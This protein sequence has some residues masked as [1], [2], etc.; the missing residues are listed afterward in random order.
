MMGSSGMLIIVCYFNQLNQHYKFVK[1]ARVQ[2][3]FLVDKAKTPE[4]S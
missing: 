4:D 1:V 2:L 3:G